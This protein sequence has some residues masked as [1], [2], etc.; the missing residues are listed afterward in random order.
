MLKYSNRSKSD[1]RASKVNADYVYMMAKEQH[2]LDRIAF[3]KE[4]S[5]TQEFFKNHDKANVSY[6][7]SMNN[8][9][10]VH[11]NIHIRREI[12]ALLKR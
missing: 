2:Y 5:Q 7:L 8:Y 11:E 4:M 9:K 6:L 10:M 1:V 3:M 12:D